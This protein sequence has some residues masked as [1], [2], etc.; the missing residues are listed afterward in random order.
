MDEKFHVG[1]KSR[2]S[3]HVCPQPKIDI[4]PITIM[5]FRRSE[6][7]T[8]RNSIMANRII[9]IMCFDTF[10]KN[11]GCEIKRGNKFTQSAINNKN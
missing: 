2:E 3:G 7:L 10:L 1:P 9:I 6:I 11:T 4:S 8:T 5:V